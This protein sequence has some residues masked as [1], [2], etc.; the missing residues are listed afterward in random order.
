M[1]KF[2]ALLLS[3]LVGWSVVWYL[4][5]NRKQMRPHTDTNELPQ[6]QVTQVQPSTINL[7]HEYIG[8]VEAIHSV[9]VY[10]YIAGFIEQVLVQGGE[11]VSPGQPLFIIKQD[12]YL[13]EVEAAEAKVIGATADL[14]KAKLYLERIDNTVNEAIS[15]T[16][17]DN[18]K[19]AFL[20]AEANLAQAKAALKLA[21]TNYNYTQ[22]SATINGVLGNI[23]ATK[24]EYVSPE[25]NALAYILQYN[26][27]RVRFSMPEKDFLNLGADTNFFRTGELKLRLA[28]NQI[29]TAKGSVR[30]ADNQIRAGTS[31]IDLFADFENKKHLLLPGAYVT[32]LYEEHLPEAFLIEKTWI[33]M[34]PD[35]TYIYTVQND[36]VQ[37]TPITLNGSFNGKFV[38]TNGLSAE[39]LIVITPVQ[40][41]MVGQKVRP[42]KEPEA[43][44]ESV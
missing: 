41:S 3:L 19:T 13:A 32:V 24:G 14:E 27:I 43:Q 37:K 26:P 25:S 9:L 21:Q 8:H 28:N 5:L 2:V 11:E 6:V 40:P 23:T 34:Q 39:D 35:G 20:T 29:I 4:C 18:A 22:I 44:D 1:K 7:T 38:V 12:Q 42:F 15:K 30:F 10:P 17:R 31:S 33:T 16:E 36:T